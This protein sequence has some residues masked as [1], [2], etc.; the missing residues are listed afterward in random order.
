MPQKTKAN[1]KNTSSVKN[2]FASPFKWPKFIVR[3]TVNILIDT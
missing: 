1:K 2:F 3:S